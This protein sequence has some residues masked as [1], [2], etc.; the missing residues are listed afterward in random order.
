MFQVVSVRLI[1][2]IGLKRLGLPTNGH[3]K[4]AEAVKKPGIGV[5]IPG[6]FRFLRECMLGEFQSGF[7]V[8]LGKFTLYNEQARQ[9][10]RIACTQSRH[11]NPVDD[12]FQIFRVPAIFCHIDS[13]LQSLCV[14][15]IEKEQVIHR[16]GDPCDLVCLQGFNKGI[17]KG[18]KKSLK[19]FPWGVLQLIGGF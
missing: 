1:A 5:H 13:H 6:F 12:L 17:F 16:L 18:K 15:R 19:W 2:G 4:I 7:R 10:V 14:A 11:G 3:F 8:L 9:L